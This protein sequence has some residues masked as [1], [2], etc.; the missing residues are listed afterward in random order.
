MIKRLIPKCKSLLILGRYNYPTGIFL[1]FWPCLWGLSIEINQLTNF[2]KYALLFASGSLIMRGAGCCINDIIDR[3]IDSKVK[4]TK[5]RP[6]VTGSVTVREAIIFTA[7][8]LLIGLL[9]LI[10]F[11]LKIIIFGL[12]IMPLVILY[13]LFKRVTYFPQI[14]LGIVFNWGIIL[15]YLVENLSINFDVFCL[16][17]AGILMT[18][19]YDT[20][21]GLQDVRYD[22]KNKIKSFSIKIM[23]KPV[24]GVTCIY[25]GSFS[26]FC[27]YFLSINT[28][29]LVRFFSLSIILLLFTVQINLLHRKFDLK[30]IFDINSLSGGI[31]WVI[32][33][34]G[35]Y[36]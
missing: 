25:G 5:N 18:V 4:R 14:I 28:D 27:F 29:P 2:V 34:S 12:L 17:F 35:N 32:I 31:I 36:L 3:K 15:G 24:W 6:L 22:I 10:Q 33:F 11:N 16:Y 23:A 7:L 13:P 30:K 9:I 20:I 21:Y 26:F 8:Q 19:G 1:L